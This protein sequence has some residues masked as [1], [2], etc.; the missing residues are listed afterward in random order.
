MAHRPGR[1]RLLGEPGGPRRAGT[2]AWDDLGYRR[3]PEGD[4]PRT[5]PIPE[6]REARIRPA[7]LADRYDAIVVGSG[8]GGGV[9][10]E[11]LAASGRQVLVVEAGDWPELADVTFDHLRNP[12]QVRGLRLFSGPPLGTTRIAA[13]GAAVADPSDGRWSNNAMSVGGGTRYY[14]AQ[15]WRLTPDDFRMRSVYGRPDGSD[16]PDWPFGYDELEPYYTRAE[17][18]MGVSG[19]VAGDP[20]PG[21]GRATTRCRR[22]A[23]AAPPRCCGAAPP[24][25][26]GARRRCRC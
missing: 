7:E 13:D 4:R 22:C 6:H 21:R 5:P 10:A 3:W 11:A 20:A 14:G 25:S 2:A 8:A 24:G 26:A 17:V 12:R 19:S 23:P 16:L 9:A 18:E 15:A 1:R